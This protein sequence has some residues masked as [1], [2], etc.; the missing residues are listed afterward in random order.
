MQW[1][2]SSQ[3]FSNDWLEIQETADPWD[4]IQMDSTIVL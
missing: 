4:Q 2:I 1:V 3:D